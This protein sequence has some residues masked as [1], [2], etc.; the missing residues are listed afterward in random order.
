M[1]RSSSLKD[2]RAA[3]FGGLSFLGDM[4]F[5]TMPMSYIQK[6]TLLNALFSF[7]LAKN[8]EDPKYAENDKVLE[9]VQEIRNSLAKAQTNYLPVY[10][11]HA[12]DV[13]SENNY[14]EL[15]NAT[16]ELITQLQGKTHMIEKVIMEMEPV[17]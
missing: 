9:L 10:E 1:T 17:A 11:T 12:G 6:R 14:D 2:Y 7:A 3:G 13:V 15:L 16:F 8:E 5:A 4:N